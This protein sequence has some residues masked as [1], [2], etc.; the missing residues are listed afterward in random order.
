MQNLD[1]ENESHSNKV[2]TENDWNPVTREQVLSGE[3]DSDAFW[4][5][6]AVKTIAERE[7]WK[8]ADVHPEVDITTS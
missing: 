3:H 5:Y 4:V 6:G 1:D 2:L 7:L 8:F